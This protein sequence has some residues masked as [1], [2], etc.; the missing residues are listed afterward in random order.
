MAETSI[1]DQ[2]NIRQSQ[3]WFGEQKENLP[4]YQRLLLLTVLS[5][6]Y[7]VDISVERRLG[8]R[9]FIHPCLNVHIKHDIHATHGSK[10]VF[11]AGGTED[12]ELL[13][14][15]VSKLTVS[16][17]WKKFERTGREGDRQGDYKE[18]SSILADQQRPSYMSPN[19]G[20]GGGELRG[21]SQ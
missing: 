17:R 19:A 14:Q 7:F 12:S 13:A 1:W 8:F 15:Q 6:N 16:A 21:L 9:V 3:V 18:M 20:G 2:A 4:N 10:S 11:L 5:L